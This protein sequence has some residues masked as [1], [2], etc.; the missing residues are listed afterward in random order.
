[1]SGSRCILII[2]QDQGIRDFI[3]LTLGDEGYTALTASSGDDAIRLAAQHQL[4]LILLDLFFPKHDIGRFLDTYRE[5]PGPRAPLVVLTT[6]FHPDELAAQVQADDFL[7]KP[8]EL[9]DL[10]NLVSRYT[11]ATA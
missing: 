1:M 11:Q 5:M 7:S 9:S 6:D 2:D 10:L 8:F 3:S 4:S